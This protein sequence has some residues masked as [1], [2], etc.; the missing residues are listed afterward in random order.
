MY[1]FAYKVQHEPYLWNDSSKARVK[2][3][4]F[5]RLGLPNLPARTFIQ[6]VSLHRPQ[7]TSV[8][9]K[10]QDGFKHNCNQLVCD[11]QIILLIDYHLK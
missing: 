1:D 4:F 2:Q 5:K 9:K 3:P 8:A 11:I 10:Y 7:K 6:K